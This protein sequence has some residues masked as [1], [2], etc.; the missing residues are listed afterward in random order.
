MASSVGMV[1]GVGAVSVGGDALPDAS[2]S[3]L[4]SGAP[5]E[6]E[7]GPAASPGTD[8]VDLSGGTSSPDAATLLGQHRPAE[9]QLNPKRLLALLSRKS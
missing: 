1:P 8:V 3:R 4:A 2:G 5:V 7:A 6:R 9:L